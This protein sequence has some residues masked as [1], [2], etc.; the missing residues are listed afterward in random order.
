MKAPLRSLL[1]AAGLAA[2]GLAQAEV[3]IEMH[4]I[5]DEGV[6]DAIGTVTA[7]EQDGGLRLT[8]DLKDLPPGEHGFHV[9]QNP[10]CGPGEKDGQMKAGAAAGDHLDP[11]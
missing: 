11:Q 5:H 7:G 2:A 1:M 3:T 9:H 10:D 6:G 4:A 8:P